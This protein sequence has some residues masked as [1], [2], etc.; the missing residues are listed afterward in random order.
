MPARYL[1]LIAVA[2]FLAA[3]ALLITLAR[4]VL[5]P[6]PGDPEVASMVARVAVF[7]IAGG[8][9]LGTAWVFWR[10]PG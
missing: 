7:T 2:A 3:L 8:V 9:A 6:I 10:H 4:A 5:M 1:P